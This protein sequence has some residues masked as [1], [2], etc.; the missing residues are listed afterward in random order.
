MKKVLSL[1]LGVTTGWA[2]HQLD[3][4]LL[5]HGTIAYAAYGYALASLR[6]SYVVSYSV[7]EMP[8]LTYRGKLRVQL[9]EVVRQTRRE[10]MRQVVEIQPADWKSTPS[11]KAKVPRG[12]TQHERDA[13]RIGLW[14]L[15]QL[16]GS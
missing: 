11:A 5:G 13:I 2:V 10:L 6:D 3:G 12:I 8:L 4:R 1:D 7:A 16:Q 14:Y 15:V 9:E